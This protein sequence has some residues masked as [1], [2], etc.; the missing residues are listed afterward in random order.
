MAYPKMTSK[1]QS[2]LNIPLYLQK[3]DND[4]FKKN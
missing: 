3:K 4:R 1:V 2:T